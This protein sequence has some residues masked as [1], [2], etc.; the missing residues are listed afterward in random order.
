MIGIDLVDVRRFEATTRLPQF[1]KRFHVSGDSPL[2]VAKTWA[3]LEAIIKAEDQPFD[4]TSISIQ[5]VAGQRP[6]V[7]DPHN[8]LSKPYILSL[9]H[10]ADLVI[11]VALR[12]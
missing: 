1:I 2:D 3:C 8:I 9:S 7:N 5:F 10:D 4:P 12:T 6:Q 11:A